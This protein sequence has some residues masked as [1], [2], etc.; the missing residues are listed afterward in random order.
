[1]KLT[2]ESEMSGKAPLNLALT[3]NGE[4]QHNSGLALAQ[5]LWYQLSAGK[6]DSGTCSLFRPWL[7]RLNFYFNLSLKTAPSGLLG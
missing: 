6:S 7:A 5:A 2:C 1:M 4:F 3:S